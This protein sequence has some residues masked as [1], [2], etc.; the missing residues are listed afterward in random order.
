MPT[1]VSADVVDPAAGVFVCSPM[2]SG[3]VE[4]IGGIKEEEAIGKKKKK[5]NGNGNKKR[6]KKEEKREIGEAGSSS[7]VLFSLLLTSQRF[8]NS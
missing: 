6:K 4:P 3:G 7:F 1:F 5:K 2:M 8:Y